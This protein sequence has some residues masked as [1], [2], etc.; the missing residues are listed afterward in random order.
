M[1]IAV[2]F[3]SEDGQLFSLFNSFCLNGF[4]PN[5]Y[6]SV[7]KFVIYHYALNSVS[8]NSLTLNLF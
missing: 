1:F 6:V 7:L 3:V 4:S 2:V 8:N 5:F